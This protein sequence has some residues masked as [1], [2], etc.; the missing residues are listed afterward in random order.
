MTPASRTRV[1]YEANPSTVAATLRDA[2]EASTTRTTGASISRA[3]CAVEAYPSVP[4]APSKRP[5]TPSMTAMSAPE[6]PW[7]S[8]GISLS[9]PCRNGSRLRAGRPVA[10]AW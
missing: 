5:I 3:T 2:A 7:R 6:E 10:S 4:K 9:S 1:S 8:N